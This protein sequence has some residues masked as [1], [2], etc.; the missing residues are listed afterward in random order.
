MQMGERLAER[1]GGL[2]AV[3]PTAEH[4]R[5]QLGRAV[6]PD[7][8]GDDLGAARV[9]MRRQLVD[10]RIKPAERQVVRGQHEDVGRQCAPQL[11]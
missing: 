2:V 11:A 3:E 9:M 4:D 10:P 8:G 5:Q 7:A 1:E 6:R